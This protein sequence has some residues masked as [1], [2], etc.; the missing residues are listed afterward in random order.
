[1]QTQP[2]DE[3]VFLDES[4]THLAMTPLYARSLRGTRAVASVPRTRGERDV[5]LH[6]LEHG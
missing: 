2:S 1:V 6:A 3:F 4:S 5:D